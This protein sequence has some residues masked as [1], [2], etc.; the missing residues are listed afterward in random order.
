MP[1]FLFLKEGTT[2]AQFLLE[3]LWCTAGKNSQ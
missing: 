2:L 1:F 3:V